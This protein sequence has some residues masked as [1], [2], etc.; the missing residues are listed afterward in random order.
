MNILD[1]LRALAHSKYPA[2]RISRICD[3]K[4]SEKDEKNLGS[5]GRSSE[6][7][8]EV[9]VTLYHSDE[10]GSSKTRG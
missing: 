7:E 5:C 2:I 1:G 8:S 9:P 3:G 10:T 6:L 4:K